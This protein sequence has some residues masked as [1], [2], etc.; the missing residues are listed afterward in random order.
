MLWTGTMIRALITG[1]TGFIGRKV[2]SALLSRG[3]QVTVLT[4][5]VEGAKGKLDP[6]VRVAGWDPAALGTWTEEVEGLDVLVNL[7]GEGIFDQPWTKDRIA[8]LKASRIAVTR[9]LSLAVARA[10]KKPKLMVSAS[11]VGV[12][13]MHRGMHLDDATFDESGA[14]G[15]GVLADICKGWEKAADPAREAGVR[16]V[17]PRLG[18]VLGGDGGALAKMSRPIKWF[19]GGPLGDGK[20]WVS[21]I[22]WKDVVDAIGFA[23]EKPELTGPVNFVSPS[24]VTMNQLAHDIGLVLNRSARFHVPP[25][26]VKMMLGDGPAEALLTGQRVL[27]NKL[28]GAGYAFG[29]PDLLPALEDLLGPK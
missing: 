24:P 17:H 26:A 23:H 19:V 4:R 2:T 28:L 7:A 27:P 5:S 25:F 9:N 16:V 10:R 18:I 6:R 29:W 14:L 11:A 12:Y 22:H 1:G 15:E 8:D 21:W 3:W 13:G 20:Q